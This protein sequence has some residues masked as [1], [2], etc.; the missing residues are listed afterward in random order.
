MTVDRQ[1]VQAVFL[2]A[3]EVP[4]AQRGALLDSACAGDAELRQCVESLLLAH[5]Q[6]GSFLGHPADSVVNTR[7]GNSSG[8]AALND[9]AERPGTVIGPY[10]LL[11]AIGEG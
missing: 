8:A 5:D 3:V 6:P 1:Q 11:E 7:A 9:P 10:K 4:P 2:Q